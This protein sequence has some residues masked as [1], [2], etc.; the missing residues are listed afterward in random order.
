MNTDQGALV[1]KAFSPTAPVFVEMIC[2][3]CGN[4]LLSAGLTCCP[5]CETQLEKD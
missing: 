5:F 3:K 2:P 1:L 4:R